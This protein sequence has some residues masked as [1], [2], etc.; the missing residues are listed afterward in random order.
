MVLIFKGGHANLS[1]FS[2]MG[3]ST[4]RVDVDNVVGIVKS[5]LQQKNADS[6]ELIEA[7][8]KFQHHDVLPDRL[9][10]IIVLILAVMTIGL[11]IYT[12][13][14]VKKISKLESSANDDNKAL[15]LKVANE[16][17]RRLTRSNGPLDSPV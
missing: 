5:T 11:A 12:R 13:F 10:D 14:L 8:N 1:V 2:R 16:N 4:S 9:S 3:A 6:S 15:R 17:F 7:L